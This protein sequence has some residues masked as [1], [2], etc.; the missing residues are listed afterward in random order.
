[1]KTRIIALT[2]SMALWVSTFLSAKYFFG[3]DP[4]FW[5]IIVVLT[6]GGLSNLPLILEETTT[7]KWFKEQNGIAKLIVSKEES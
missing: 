5:E 4:S 1:M 2:V 6:A 3:I 7:V